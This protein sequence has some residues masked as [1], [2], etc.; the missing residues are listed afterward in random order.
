MQIRNHTEIVWS[1]PVLRP[2]MDGWMDGGEERSYILQISTS[3]TEW[4]TEDLLLRWIIYTSVFICRHAIG[5]VLRLLFGYSSLNRHSFSAQTPLFHLMARCDV[6]SSSQTYFRL[7]DCEVISFNLVRPLGVLPNQ[8]KLIVPG[9]CP[10]LYQDLALRQSSFIIQPTHPPLAHLAAVAQIAGRD[11]DRDI[12][13]GWNRATC[14]P[15]L[16]SVLRGSSLPAWLM[17]RV[18]SLNAFRVF[19]VP[20]LENEDERGPHDKQNAPSHFSPCCCSWATFS[21][22][23][24]GK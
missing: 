20:K 23:V 9:H 12:D 2:W 8:I 1:F 7:M 22:I 24:E 13:W 5:S 18:K 14:F 3:S 11:R 17:I 10:K 6:G 15:A 19:V 21:I 4:M 16:R